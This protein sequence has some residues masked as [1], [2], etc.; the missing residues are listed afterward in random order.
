L[1][2]QP[3]KKNPGKLK[4]VK[5]QK[6][7]KARKNATK[8]ISRGAKKA[9]H[10]E[11]VLGHSNSTAPALMAG[12]DA[13]RARGLKALNAE[14]QSNA[15]SS[16][17]QSERTAKELERDSGI[18][19][20]VR[21][22]VTGPQSNDPERVGNISG[23]TGKGAEERSATD[24]DVKNDV[25][26]AETKKRRRNTGSRE[27]LLNAALSLFWEKGY[28]ETSVAEVFAR[29]GVRPGSMYH[30][31]KSKEDLLLG[32]LDR[33]AEILYPALLAPVWE[34]E[35]DPIERV[36]GL[37]E[38]YRK[39]ILASNFNY[40][41]PVGR[42]AVEVSG[43]LLEVHKKIA[44]NFEGWSKAV[45][46]CLEDAGSRFPKGMD[47]KMLS[48]FVLTVMEGGV[49]QSRSYKS[50]EPFDQGVAQLRDYFDRLEAQGRAEVMQAGG[51][52][53]DLP[54]KK[55]RGPFPR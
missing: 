14:A 36:F 50:I 22:D 3:N 15:E 25:V 10:A 7:G 54:K 26:L 9:E 40:G 2:V 5:N 32:V 17:R 11:G 44:M 46:K 16:Q 52:Y 34:V 19:P 53:W 37:L 43:D 24:V 12:G 47:L 35:S 51:S 27:E 13:E 38:V 42:L 4:K 49:M 29:S 6:K 39:G 31:F 21:S 30:H 23:E 33:L 48:H 1:N 8:N 41:C 28:A 20:G 18:S 55:K 45:Q